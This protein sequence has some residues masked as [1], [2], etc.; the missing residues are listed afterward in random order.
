MFSFMTQSINVRH[1][2][3]A[4]FDP[5]SLHSHTTFIP[6]FN[7]LNFLDWSEQVQFHLGVF[8]LDLA[9]QVEKS[10]TIMN[11]SYNVPT[12]NYLNKVNKIRI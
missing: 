3:I 2:L 12:G 9:F 10:A 6:V 7:G 4:I 1:V 5:V 8:D 11:V